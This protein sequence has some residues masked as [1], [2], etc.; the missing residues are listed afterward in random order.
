[1]SVVVTVLHLV[2]GVVVVAVVV[3]G[4]VLGLMEVR[5]VRQVVVDVVVGLF[6]VVGIHVLDVVAVVVGLLM[7]TNLVSV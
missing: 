5:V 4:D 3:H 6:V 7:M 1:V 2:V